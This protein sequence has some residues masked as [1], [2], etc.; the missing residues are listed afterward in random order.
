MSK[1]KIRKIIVSEETFRKIKEEMIENLRKKEEIELVAVPAAAIHEQK[2]LPHISEQAPCLIVEVV[3]EETYSESKM[4]EELIKQF[5]KSINI[6]IPE[7]FPLSLKTDKVKKKYNIPRTIGKPNS[8][9][10]GSR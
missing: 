7:V 2:V 9:K 4:Q 5:K 6:N 8:M 10:K 1:E 3:N